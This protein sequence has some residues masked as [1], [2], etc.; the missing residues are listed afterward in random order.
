MQLIHTIFEPRGDG[1][2]PTILTLHGWGANA[3]DLLGLAP[4]IAGGRFLVICPPGPVQ[5]PPEYGAV[6]YGW[7]PIVPGAGGPP[8]MSA[9]LSARQ[10][11]LEFL[12][13]AIERYAIDPEKLLLLGFSQGGVMAYTLALST[14]QRFQALMALS[15]W[16]PPELMQQ[17]SDPSGLHK[18]PTLIQHG[19][20]DQL[21][22]VERAR[23]SVQ[24]L[25]ELRLP[26]TYR[27][28]DIGHE[29]SGQS[30]M[31]LSS[32]LQDKVLSPFVTG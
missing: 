1:P 10:Q 16:L 6:G 22:E 5:L 8:D 30:L 31:D 27:E 20:R 2:H 3:L 26:L 24:S 13:N 29:I 4:H 21:V 9:V 11:L 32:W 17:V 15:T 28:Y 18:L 23:K 12:D 25:R 19:S 7:Y 14:P